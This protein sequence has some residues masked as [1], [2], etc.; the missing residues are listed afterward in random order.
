MHSSGPIPILQYSELQNVANFK[1]FTRNI[2][3]DLRMPQ[4]VGSHKGKK[5]K[6][7]SIILFFIYIKELGSGHRRHCPLDNTRDQFT[8]S[9]L[10]LC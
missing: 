7:E 5:R 6:D 8:A 1:G 4:E 10:P 2:F 9:H 3:D